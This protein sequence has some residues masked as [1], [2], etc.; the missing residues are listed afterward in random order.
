MAKRE[1]PALLEGHEGVN[2]EMIY[3]L[4]NWE[5]RIVRVLGLGFRNEKVNWDCEFLNTSI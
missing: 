2:W 4:I 1:W 5:N 3:A